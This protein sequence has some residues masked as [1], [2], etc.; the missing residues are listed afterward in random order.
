MSIGKTVKRYVEEVFPNCKVF[1]R[2][3]DT[4]S[5]PITHNQDYLNFPWDKIHVHFAEPIFAYTFITFSKR[6]K[7]GLLI[8][9]VCP[10]MSVF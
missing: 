5:K 9:V 7:K 1:S 4:P 10:S 8:R 6:V 3:N 2:N